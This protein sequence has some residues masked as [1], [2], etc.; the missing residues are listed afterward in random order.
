MTATAGSDSS[1]VR[2]GVWWKHHGVHQSS[3]TVKITLPGREKVCVCMHYF[4]YISPKKKISPMT[5]IMMVLSTVYM[6]F[7]AI[8]LHCHIAGIQAETLTSLQ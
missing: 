5:E 7:S 8:L 1:S 6:V 2:T 4:S 3:M